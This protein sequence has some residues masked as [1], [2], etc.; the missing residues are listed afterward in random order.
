MGKC[1]NK[2]GIFN[3]IVKGASTQFGREFGRAGANSILK[4]KNYYAIKGSSDY[5]GRIKPSDSDVV[6]V[7]KEINKITFPTTDKAILNKLIQM[8]G[9]VKPLIKFD[10]NHFNDVS[11]LTNLFGEKF[12]V[13]ESLLSTE[14]KETEL[15]NAWIK[16]KEENTKLLSVLFSDY[17]QYVK[18]N[19]DYFEKK[20]KSKKI[21][22]LLT[23]VFGVING[24]LLYIFKN[25]RT[26]SNTIG[27][28]IASL[29]FC[30]TFIPAIAGVITLLK[31]LFMSNDNFD[32]VYNSE[33][34]YFKN[35]IKD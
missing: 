14:C 9:M 8:G 19:F 4:G 30:W 31:L 21:A 28:F 33:Y 35:L 11:N 18:E 17:K 7:I 2:M 6:R 32:K 15:I 13:G 27:W 23:L 5:N 26:K 10:I 16:I 29:I 20:K 12:N 25:T 24:Q 3:N 34:I 1:N 22:L